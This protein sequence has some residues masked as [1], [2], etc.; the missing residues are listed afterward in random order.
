MDLF[1]SYV[2]LY[3]RIDVF[4]DPNARSQRRQGGADGMVRGG[5]GG[6]AADQPPNAQVSVEEASDACDPW[7]LLVMT[8]IAM[9]NHHFQWENPENP[10]FLWP[11][12]IAM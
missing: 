5:V 1:H 3:Q 9:E 10:L 6:A 7:Y 2:T 8:N 4:D 12:S 11:C